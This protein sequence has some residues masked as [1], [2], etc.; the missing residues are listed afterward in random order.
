[1]MN[2]A[3]DIEVARYN[4]HLSK[5]EKI[6]Y[7]VQNFIFNTF[8]FIIYKSKPKV[9][10]FVFYIIILVLILFALI[11]LV[12]QVRQQERAKKG[13]E[14][15]M[16]NAT[17][18]GY[19]ENKKLTPLEQ[20]IYSDWCAEEKKAFEKIEISKNK[21]NKNYDT[22]LSEIYPKID[23][24]I[25]NKYN[26]TTEEIN[27]IMDVGDVIAAKKM[28]QKEIAINNRLEEIKESTLEAKIQVAREFNVTLYEVIEAEKK[29][30]V[31]LNIEMLGH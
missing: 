7:S 23:A 9:M 10:E 28:T 14:N 13:F 18:L 6:S 16:E 25:M 20:Q 11:T 17:S 4:L 15:F 26:L 29:Y 27:R 3:Q 1:M 12:K 21:W 24:L 31:N 19:A 8:V 22:F 30:I 5:K 2:F